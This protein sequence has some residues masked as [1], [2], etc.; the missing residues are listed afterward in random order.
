MNNLLLGKQLFNYQEYKEIHIHKISIFFS[1]IHL[2]LELESSPDKP[3]NLIFW[4]TG[5]WFLFHLENHSQ[6]SL[7]KETIRNN[8]LI[9]LKLT[10]VNRAMD[11][12]W[13]V[14]LWVSVWRKWYQH[15]QE[16]ACISAM[17]IWCVF[18]CIPRRSVAL[19]NEEQ[20]GFDL[21][22]SVFKILGFFFNCQ[23]GN[24]HRKPWEAI[25]SQFPLVTLPLVSH[26]LEFHC[27]GAVNWFSYIVERG[28]VWGWWHNMRI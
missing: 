8:V 18:C 12:I 11:R 1:N 16:D 14:C 6:N 2:S 20:S 5:N 22:R 25:G 7:I 13:N 3:K 19:N 28:Q 26:H 27:L 10:F 9:L 21:I 24:A 15:Q 17:R 23:I 4:T